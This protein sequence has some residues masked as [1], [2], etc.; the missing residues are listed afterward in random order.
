MMEVSLRVS[1]VV[2]YKLSLLMLKS[3]EC[4]SSFCRATNMENTGR[5]KVSGGPL[6]SVLLRLV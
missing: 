5:D 3:S 2:S 1:S 6:C 4:V